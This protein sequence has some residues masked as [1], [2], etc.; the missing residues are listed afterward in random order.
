MRPGILPFFPPG[1]GTWGTHLPATDIQESS[2]ETCS[3][4]FTWGYPYWYWHLVATETPMAGKPAVRILLEYFLVN[5]KFKVV[6]C[7]W[8]GLLSHVIACRQTDVMCWKRSSEICVLCVNDPGKTAVKYAAYQELCI[9]RRHHLSFTKEKLQAIIGP[10]KFTEQSQTRMM[11][12][13]NKPNNS[14]Y[15]SRFET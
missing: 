3:N 12:R 15:L 2:L 6:K 14:I 9:G 8:A 13:W 1:L 4:L 11:C 5:N 10:S 7:Q